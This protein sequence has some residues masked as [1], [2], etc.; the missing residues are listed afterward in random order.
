M[1]EIRPAP[2]KKTKVQQQRDFNMEATRAE[3]RNAS[4]L[5]KKTILEIRVLKT[6]IQKDKMKMRCMEKSIAKMDKEM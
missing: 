4:L 6:K 2:K 1:K 3:I 5:R